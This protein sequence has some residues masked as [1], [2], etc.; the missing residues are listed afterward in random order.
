MDHRTSSSSLVGGDLGNSLWI[1]QE[2]Q[3]FESV[4][5]SIYAIYDLIEL[6]PDPLLAQQIREHVVCIEDSFVNSQEWTLSRSVPD[7]RLGIVGSLSSGKSA[8]VHR[9]L[10]GSYMQEDSPEGGR[11]KKEIVVDGQSYLLLIRDEGGPPELQFTS[12]VDAVIF[13]F[14]LENETSFNAIYNY[15]AKMSQFRNLQEIPLILVGTQDAI[16]ENHPRVIDDSRARKLASDLKRC[17]YYETCATYG[18]NVERVFQD[19]CQKLCQARNG[20][21]QHSRPTT[22]NHF[23]PYPAYVPSPPTNGYAQVQPP[24]PSGGLH[25]QHHHS[26]NSHFGLNYPPPPSH[27]TQVVDYSHSSFNNSPGSF[28]PP[29]PPGSN[30]TGTM[31]SSSS[32]EIGKFVVPSVGGNKEN[33]VGGENKENKELPTPSSTPTSSRKNRRRSNLFTPSKKSD[34][35]NNG[36]MNNSSNNSSG[37]TGQQQG[38]IQQQMGSG[39]S[40]PIRQG[41]LYKKSNKSFSKD[42]KKK[43]VTL[44]DDGRMTYHPSLHDYMDNIHGK[45]ISLQY[46][47]V[48]VPG[49]KPRG[50]RTIP[51][52]NPNLEN[53][54]L[55][56][57]GLPS[58]VGSTSSSSKYE[59]VMLTGYEMLREPSGG[60]ENESNALE[61]SS[62]SSETPNVK[63]RHRRIRSNGIKASDA[64]EETSS[65]EERDTWVSAIEQQILNSLQGIESSKSSKNPN[66]IVDVQAIKAI[67]SE[68]SGNHKCVDCDMHRKLGSHISRVRSLDLDEWPPGHLA[69]MLSTGNALANSNWE[70]NFRGWR[71]PEPNSSQEEKEQFIMAKYSRKE[72]LSHLPP[73]L[74]P[75]ASLVEAICR[76]D[77]KGVTLALAH[78]SQ[79][80]VNLPISPRDNRSP[81]HLASSLGNLAIA[82]L[83]ILV[84]PE[85][86]WTELYSSMIRK[87]KSGGS[88][89]RKKNSSR[90]PSPT[91]EPKEPSIEDLKKEIE[92]EQK[93]KNTLEWSNQ[94]LERSV[95]AMERNVLQLEGGNLSIDDSEEKQKYENQ[96]HLNVQLQEQKKWL[97]HELEQIKIK[98]QNDKLHPLPNSFAL[99]WDTLSE[100]ELKRLVM[101]LEKTKN[102]IISDLREVEWKMDKEG[103]DFHHY[104]DFVQSYFAEIKNLN[105]TIDT[106]IQKG[107]LPADYH[108]KNGST[109]TT[110][111]GEQMIKTKAPGNRKV[112]SNALSPPLGKRRI[113]AY[114]QAQK[115]KLIDFN[116][117]AESSARNSARTRSMDPKL[118]PIRKTATVRNLPKINGG[119]S[120]VLSNLTCREPKTTLCHKKRFGY[121][122]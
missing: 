18:L 73:N 69:V 13:V 6:V 34:N 30:N 37:S 66:S 39:R 106:L 109:I 36:A 3:R 88:S 121:G 10:T 21:I 31:N 8:L 57:T 87:K 62:S 23:R 90:T 7:I 15:Y 81:L 65:C 98:I 95:T 33:N 47:T 76:S 1:R 116:S 79:E 100:T 78:A 54:N 60:E 96:K 19:A 63:K 93:A 43:Y 4:H 67:K 105:R 24:S 32:S 14:S 27:N 61:K 83:L 45:E 48:K 20:G 122:Y 97:E 75:A 77:M 82:Q 110:A 16:S 89:N 64:N 38:G 115:A 71:K 9:Y 17:S 117:S 49:Q 104:D 12:W 70:G 108:W 35:S 56:L 101:E 2:I 51:Q 53:N 50:S 120:G 26:P 52:T 5:P 74:S 112:S 80:D 42:W 46:V 55:K 114:E 58:G 84:I 28:S 29:P 103:R 25:H 22:P 92:M 72:F 68:I 113:S 44:C 41:M 118:G 102:D 99:D 111:I 94:E 91:K 59:K 40:I 107:L 11:F 85:K 86:L 119:A